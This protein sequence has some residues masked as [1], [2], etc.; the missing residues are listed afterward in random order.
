[1]TAMRKPPRHRYS[2]AVFQKTTTLFRH[3]AVMAAIWQH[4]F[5]PRK[6]AVPNVERLSSTSDA[7]STSQNARI[8]KGFVTEVGWR[9]KPW[10]K[11]LF[12]YLNILFT[13]VQWESKGVAI[14]WQTLLTPKLISGLVRVAYYN[15]PTTDL[16]RVGSWKASTPCLDNLQLET[17]GEEIEWASVMLVLWSKSLMYLLSVIK[18][19]LLGRYLISRPRK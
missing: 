14:S 16:Y 9:S 13:I 5:G 6:I 3:C 2:V 11:M 8:T 12:R 4:W 15:A 7:Q 18:I 19:E 1:M 10:N 17:I